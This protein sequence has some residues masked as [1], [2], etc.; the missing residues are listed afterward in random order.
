LAAYYA[1]K[2]VIG[3]IYFS[4]GNLELD[5]AAREE[6]R[7]IARKIDLLEES[8]FQSGERL[9]IRI[10]GHTDSSGDEDMNIFYSLMRAAAVEEYLVKNEKV[11]TELYLTGFGEKKVL[12]GESTKDERARNRRVDIVRIFGDGDFLKVL[13]MGGPVLAKSEEVGEA[14]RDDV[15]TPEPLKETDPLAGIAPAAPVSESADDLNVSGVASIRAG[16]FE[17]ASEYLESALSLD[18]KHMG[19]R[20]NLGFAYQQMARY[21]DAEREY[22]LVLKMEDLTKVHLMLGVI[23]EKRGEDA[24]ALTEF[25]TVLAREPD[26]RT[27][28]SKSEQLREKLKPA[29][30]EPTAAELNSR[31]AALVKEGRLNEAASLFEKALSLDEKHMGAR[32]NLGLVYQRMAR[33][34]DAEREYRLVLDMEDLAKVH[35][36]LGIIHEKR[37]E[38]ESAI[39]E[40]DTVL[41]TEPDNKT[42]INK[43]Q[44]LIE[45]NKTVE[46]L[47]QDA[48]DH[49]KEN[50]CPLA[51]EVYKRIIEKSPDDY[52]AYFN[53]G[54][55]SLSMGLYME[56][57]DNF[58]QAVSLKESP[59][60]YLMK[61][62]SLLK[63]GEKGEAQKQFEKVLELDPDNAE[64][65]K[66]LEN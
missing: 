4:K 63:L 26:N 40:F 29:P 34:D 41:A 11:L 6:L 55:C 1:G 64:V 66:Y 45:K 18:E 39:I 17:A 38:D 48:A 13:R 9:I 33:Y 57:K 7:K 54:L 5:S 46:E 20:F 35:L 12:V 58:S 44:R 32:F 51:V 16:D 22:R 50:K 30:P 43:R 59:R 19:A 8:S 65:K 42:A 15:A 53:L 24:A 3:S 49:L 37:G 2:E 36:M 56:A 27:A 23:H 60:T 61:G 25:E 47:L 31:G 52:R 21:D 28:K 14:A 62:I 10:E